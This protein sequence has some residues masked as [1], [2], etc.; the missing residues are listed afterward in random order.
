MA[1]MICQSCDTE[2]TNYIIRYQGRSQIILC[3]PCANRGRPLPRVRGQQV[4]A[5]YSDNQGNEVHVDG[6]GRVV[7]DSPYN[8]RKDRFGWHY[9]GKTK[10][11]RKG[12]R[13]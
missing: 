6:K 3:K 2:T 4:Q 5:I 10:G 7:D 9:G 13:Y 8:T 12:E 11:R 1:T